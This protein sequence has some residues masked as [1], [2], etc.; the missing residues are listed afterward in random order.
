MHLPL[1]LLS[2]AGFAAA[3]AVRITDPVLPQIADAFTTTV[4]GAA[5]TVTTFTLG[6][7]FAQ[8]AYG[9]LA[10][11]IGKLRVMAFALLVSAL[12]A[13]ACAWAPTLSVLAGLRLL[14]G[15]AGAAA[16]PLS[17]AYIADATPY[18]TRQTT[19]GRFMS[20][21]MLGNILS[22]VVGGAIGDW[23]GWRAIFG[24]LAAVQCVIAVGLLR[25]VRGE[26]VAHAQPPSWRTYA[27]LAK[28]RYAQRVLGAAIVEG[29]MLIG[30]LPFLGALLKARF[31]LSYLVIGLILAGIAVGSLFFTLSV[32]V[33]LRR[34][35]ER[36]LLAV[37]G[38]LCGA[39]FLAAIVIPHWTLSIPVML[40]IGFGFFMLHNTMQALASEIAPTSRATS[41]TLFVFCIFIGQGIGAFILGALIDHRGYATAFGTAA[42]IVVALG[43]W[44]ARNVAG[45]RK[46]AP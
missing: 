21:V 33:L 2:A 42:A 39:G 17:M 3:A 22:V 7:G 44:L 26:P 38:L 41:L 5:I 12:L 16:I 9:P 45:Q 32:R 25:A 10:D 15:A 29:A 27:E 1:L 18:A 30:A 19:M 8:L 13:A 43:F 36:R 46:S 11:R 35:G 6:Y 14:A 23:L 24:T 34:L 4:G 28:R 40:A 31:D 20:A 37:G